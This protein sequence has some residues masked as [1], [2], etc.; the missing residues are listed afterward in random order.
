[1]LSRMGG[2][3]AQENP[4]TEVC[5]TTECFS[6]IAALL[7]Q[8]T[9]PFDNLCSPRN[10]R[11]TRQRLALGERNMSGV[12]IGVM[13]G[14]CVVLCGAFFLPVVPPA[15]QGSASLAHDPKLIEDLVYAN[16]ILYQ[17]A[18]LDG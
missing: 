8:F 7:V 12:R 6:L 13:V 14:V 4:Q 11:G 16:R 15:F 1:M 9:A 3:R 17:Q 18:V 5:A 10:L 2:P